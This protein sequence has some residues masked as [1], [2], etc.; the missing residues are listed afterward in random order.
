VTL[1]DGAAVGIATALPWN[2]IVMDVAMT[3]DATF[4]GGGEVIFGTV[5]DDAPH[6]LTIGDTADASKTILQLAGTV[7]PD[8]T[9]NLVNNRLTTQPGAVLDATTEI[10]AT[11]DMGLGLPQNEVRI[12]TGQDGAAGLANGTIYLAGNNF[13]RTYV[14]EVATGETPT[15]A[16]RPS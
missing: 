14:D 13:V 12:R 11:G 2:A 7:G 6:T 1:E 10:Y 5:T 16:T 15:P 4:R 9:F 3:G 8:I